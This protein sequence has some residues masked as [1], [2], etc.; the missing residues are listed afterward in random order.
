MERARETGTSVQH[1]VRAQIRP[2]ISGGPS[3][4]ERAVNW[5]RREMLL[6]LTQERDGLRGEV[7]RIEARIHELEPG[8][9][10]RGVLQETRDVLQTRARQLD[11]KIAN[12]QQ[13]TPE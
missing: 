5:Y 6:V 12:F 13:V 7:E 11:V 3:P 10:F 1:L 9:L 2:L 8:S 4:F